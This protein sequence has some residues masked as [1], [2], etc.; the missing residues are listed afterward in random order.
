MKFVRVFALLFALLGV[1]AGVQNL[2]N[3][4]VLDTLTWESFGLAVIQ[5]AVAGGFGYGAWLVTTNED[6]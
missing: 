4:F 2:G 5:I 6:L 3:A 1:L